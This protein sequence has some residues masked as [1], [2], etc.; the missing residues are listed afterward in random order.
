MSVNQDFALYLDSLKLAKTLGLTIVPKYGD[1]PK[2]PWF[3]LVEWPHVGFV[4]S[5]QLWEF[6]NGVEHGRRNK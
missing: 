5:Q 2:D 4:S 1:D 6:L 3:S